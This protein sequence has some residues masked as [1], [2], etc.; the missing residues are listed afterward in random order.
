[1]KVKDEKLAQVN[2]G[3]SGVGT[4]FLGYFANLFNT[5]FSIGQGLGGALRRIGSNNVCRF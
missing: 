4:G 5:I 3:E 2:G 1:M